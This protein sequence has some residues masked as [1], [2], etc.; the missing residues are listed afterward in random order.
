ML[1]SPVLLT[2][3]VRKR[4]RPGLDY[5][6]DETTKGSYRNK[7]GMVDLTYRDKRNSNPI[8]SVLSSLVSFCKHYICT[9][10]ITRSSTESHDKKQ[11]IQL[12]YSGTELNDQFASLFKWI[13]FCIH[14]RCTLNIN[15][16]RNEDNGNNGISKRK[17]YQDQIDVFY[18]LPQANENSSSERKGTIVVST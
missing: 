13:S 7:K 3:V 6:E 2:F 15:R 4:I 11:T 18:T 9:I 17:S 10:D 16:S 8:Y 1:T 5:S 14:H 12:I